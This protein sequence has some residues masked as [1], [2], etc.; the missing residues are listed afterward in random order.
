MK[1]LVLLLVVGVVLAWLSIARRRSRGGRSRPGG[2]DAASRRAAAPTAM[3]G[4][5]HCG[6]HLPR[7]EALFDAAGRPY[8]SEAH[9]LAGPR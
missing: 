6:V 2:D 7:P 3:L 5:V 1:Y 9:R 4:C 8:C